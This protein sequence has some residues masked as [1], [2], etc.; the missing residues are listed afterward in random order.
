MII[1]YVKDPVNSGQKKIPISS[2]DGD[3][4]NLCISALN[5][6]WFTLEKISPHMRLRHIQQGLPLFAA[7][8]GGYWNF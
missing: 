5:V 7:D 1:S 2:L 8:G 6:Y 4:P 3:S